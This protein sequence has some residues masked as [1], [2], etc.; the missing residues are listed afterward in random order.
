MTQWKPIALALAGTLALAACGT[1]PVD[2]AVSG[3]A[4]GAATGAAA[5]ALIPG[6]P[7]WGGAA[8]GA[9]VGAITGALTDEK[10]LDLG[11]PPWR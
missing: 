6:L 10:Q 7:V 5:G 3:G 1:N 8:I 11:K 9:G 2:R 4:I